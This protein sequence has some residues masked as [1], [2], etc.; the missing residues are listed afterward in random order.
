MNEALDLVL[1]QAR[2][3]IGSLMLF[4]PL[5]RALRIVAARG[6]SQDIMDHIKNL[7]L[8][9]GQGIAGHVYQTGHPYY[10]KSPE[11]DPLFVRQNIPVGPGFQFLSI[12]LRND[13]KQT[14]GVLNIH[15]PTESVLGPDDLM[16]LSQLANRLTVK[17]LPVFNSKNQSLLPC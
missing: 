16:A 5:E 13:H 14:V 12:P 17:Y 6:F 4:D 7:R 10:L 8:T 9:P 11:D 2:A 1:R 15:F 3:K